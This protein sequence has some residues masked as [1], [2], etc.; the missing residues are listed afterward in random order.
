M[1]KSFKTVFVFALQANSKKTENVS[2]IQHVKLDTNGMENSVLLLHVFQ[3]LHMEVDV[4]VVKL[5]CL[6]VQQVLIGMVTD[7]FM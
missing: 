6:F 7:V 2:T 5:Q 3:V 4:D 1:V